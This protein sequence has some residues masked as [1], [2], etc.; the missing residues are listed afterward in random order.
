MAC[1][2][3]WLPRSFLSI[4]L[5]LWITSYRSIVAFLL[6]TC[7]KQSSILFMPSHIVMICLRTCSLDLSGTCPP[8]LNFS[9]ILRPCGLTLGKDFINKNTDIFQLHNIFILPRFISF[10]L[11]NVFCQCFL[12][13]FVEIPVEQVIQCVNISFE[14]CEQPT[15]HFCKHFFENYQLFCI[16]RL[17]KLEELQ[18]FFKVVQVCLFL[19]L[20]LVIDWLLG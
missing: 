13:P 12:Q 8:H 3:S 20:Q 11:R 15:D 16:V 4:N 1:L 17:V 5:N 2:K 18:C 19:A 10:K 6:S 7:N 9:Q 14:F